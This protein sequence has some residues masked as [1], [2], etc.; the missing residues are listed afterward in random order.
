MTPRAILLGIV[1]SIT[2]CKQPPR[3]VLQYCTWKALKLQH[4]HIE[5]LACS[6]EEVYMLS[7]ALNVTF[8]TISGKS[9]I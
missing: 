6:T 7:E 9:K 5:I 3:E 4:L 8:N 1:L 2:P